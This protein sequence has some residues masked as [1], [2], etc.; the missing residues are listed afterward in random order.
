MPEK[1]ISDALFDLSPAK[2][3]RPD[4]KKPASRLLREL[5]KRR[6]R[7]RAD[8]AKPARERKVGYE[9][10]RAGCEAIN[11][12]LEALA[13]E[14]LG[15]ELGLQRYMVVRVDDG[16]NADTLQAIEVGLICPFDSEGM[17]WKIVGRG[18]RKDGKLGSNW[19]HTSFTRARIERRRLDGTWELLAPRSSN[20][21]S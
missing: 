6:E 7:R 3:M 20:G 17:H 21:A 11:K 10:F 2:L 19:T 12:K 13:F 4:D 9:D 18:M 15:R 1:T 16:L 5:E 14:V 8:E